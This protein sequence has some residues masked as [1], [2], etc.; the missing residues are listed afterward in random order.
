MGYGIKTSYEVWPHS[1]NSAMIRN[2]DFNTAPHNNE[3]FGGLLAV[4]EALHSSGPE[5]LTAMA[6]SYEVIGALGNTGKGN[7]DP[8]GWDCP[9]HS[10]GVAM[11]VE[12]ADEAEPGPTG[13]CA[14]A[15]DGAAHADVRVPYRNSVHVERNA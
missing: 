12:Q 11:A 8:S 7:Y 13:E 2:T 3:M 6:I 1:T 4:G 5:I 14:L 10:V 9:Y 15:G